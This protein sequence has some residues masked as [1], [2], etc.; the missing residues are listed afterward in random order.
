MPLGDGVRAD[1]HGGLHVGDQAIEEDQAMP[2]Q[3]IGQAHL[4]QVDLAPLIP[5]SAAAMAAATVRV[6]ITPS[7]STGWGRRPAA[8]ASTTCGCTPGR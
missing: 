2:A 7:A 5:A 4:E 6:S 3:P 1:L 8:M